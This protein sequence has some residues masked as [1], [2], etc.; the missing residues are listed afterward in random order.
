MKILNMD[1]TAPDAVLSS[2]CPTLARMC[3]FG[4]GVPVSEK[5]A[6]EWWTKAAEYGDADARKIQ[7]WLNG[8]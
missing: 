6:E 3:S 7:E 5:D 8:N 2:V 4:R 1:V